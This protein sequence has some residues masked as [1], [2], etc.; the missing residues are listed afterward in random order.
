MPASATRSKKPSAA[1]EY[2]TVNGVRYEVPENLSAAEALRVY[3]LEIP[4]AELKEVYIPH[5]QTEHLHGVSPKLFSDAVGCRLQLGMDHAGNVAWA[6]NPAGI[7]LYS[8]S[9]G[10]GFS[11]VSAAD[12]QKRYATLAKQRETAKTLKAKKQGK[13][14]A[15]LTKKPSSVA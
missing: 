12:L 1:T 10:S 13:Q 8:S 14:I 7:E 5:T 9:S 3:M 11:T 6:V 15:V 2:V 4:V